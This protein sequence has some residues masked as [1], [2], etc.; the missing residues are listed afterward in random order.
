MEY[1]NGI[2]ILIERKNK[3]SAKFIFKKINKQSECE[4]N[5]K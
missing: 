4:L 2:T 1:N 3:F 5:F